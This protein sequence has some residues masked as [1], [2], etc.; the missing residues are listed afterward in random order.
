VVA[1]RAAHQGRGKHPSTGSNFAR[2]CSAAVDRALRRVASVYD[3]SDRRPIYSF[4]QRRDLLQMFL[5]ISCGGREI[6]D[7]RQLPRGLS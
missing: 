7:F 2:Y 3:R 5:T 6:R 4:V 1:R